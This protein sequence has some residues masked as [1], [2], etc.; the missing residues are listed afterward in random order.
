MVINEILNPEPYQLV[1][2][3]I[4]ATNLASGSYTLSWTVPARAQSYR[5]KYASNPIVEWVDFNRTTNTFIGDPASPVPWFAATNESS[6][7]A[8]AAAGTTKPSR[9]RDLTR[10][11]PGISQ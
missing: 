8:P 5:I 6:P 9:L 2:V 10:H 11:V 3:P 4:T 1:D 7:P